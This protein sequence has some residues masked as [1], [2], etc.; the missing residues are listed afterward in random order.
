MT[1]LDERRTLTRQR[2]HYRMDVSGTSNAFF[3]CLLDISASGMR[4]LCSEEVDVLNV[5]KLSVRLPKWL[6][7]GDEIR[8]QGRFV[9]CK[10]QARQRVEGGFS[11]DAL[12]EGERVLLEQ[13]VDKLTIAAMEDGL[14]SIVST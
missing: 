1:K 11:F 9:W 10:A 12:A 7:L 13:L 2:V 5:N 8:V 3:G 6:E 14:Q 4:V